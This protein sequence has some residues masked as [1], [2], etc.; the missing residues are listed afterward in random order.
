MFD[1]LVDRSPEVGHL[2][3]VGVVDEQKLVGITLSVHLLF[4]LQS[5]LLF[6][7]ISIVGPTATSEAA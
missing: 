4:P 3:N 2:Q 1:R 5:S 6:R 7:L